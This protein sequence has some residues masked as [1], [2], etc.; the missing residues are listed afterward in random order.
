M[1]RYTNDY[2]FS[3]LKAVLESGQNVKQYCKSNGLV[4]SQ[5]LHRCNRDKRRLY[6]SESIDCNSIAP[7]QT[8]Q[9][10]LNAIAAYEV[11]NVKVAPIAR[12]MNTSNGPEPSRAM[13]A[14]MCLQGLLANATVR[15]ILSGNN[16]MPVPN[17]IAEYA[18]Q[19]SDALIAE[20]QRTEK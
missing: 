13:I 7:D 9:Q 19:Y 12:T 11:A 18:V 2:D 1:M 8:P 17:L 20:L 4:Y 3:T 6:R 16:G 15:D 5:I 10:L 14:A